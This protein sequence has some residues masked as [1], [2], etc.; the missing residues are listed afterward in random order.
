MDVLQEGRNP[1]VIQ[2]ERAAQ[3]R[4]DMAVVILSNPGRLNALDRAMWQGLRD[5]LRAL[6]EDDGLRCPYHGWLYD[7]DGKLVG[8]PFMKT[9][10]DF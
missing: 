8:A 10:K 5:T 6:S 4:P 3:P 9:T 7:L 2:G 1:G